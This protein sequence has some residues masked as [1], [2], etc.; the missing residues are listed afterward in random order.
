MHGAGLS[1]RGR[2]KGLALSEWQEHYQS[3]F[4]RR[5]PGLVPI[6]SSGCH[7]LNEGIKV[8]FKLAIQA[9]LDKGLY[10]VEGGNA[11]VEP[12]PQ[13][14]GGSVIRTLMAVAKK[15]KTHI[16]EEHQQLSSV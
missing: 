12:Q 11:R 4:H 16:Y 6:S 7:L 8:M 1:D 9:R 14:L 5:Q 3:I 2:W 10:I 15:K 13:P